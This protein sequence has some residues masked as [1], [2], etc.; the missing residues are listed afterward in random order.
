[1]NLDIFTL[2]NRCN[3]SIKTLRKLGDTVYTGGQAHTFIDRGSNV[4]AVAHI[5]TVQ[6]SRAF[7]VSTSLQVV[8]SP[9]LDD[10]LGVYTILDVLPSLGIVPD[11][12]LCEDEE[13]G[14][15][16]ATHFSTNKPYHWIVEFDRGGADVVNY[17]YSDRDWNNTLEAYFPDLGWGSYTDICDLEDL[18]VKAFNVGVGYHNPHSLNAFCFTQD[19][20]NNIE[21]F[22]AFW[23]DHKNTTFPHEPL[24]PSR[25]MNWDY[26]EGWRYRP[27]LTSKHYLDSSYTY[28]PLE[29]DGEFCPLCEH[30]FMDAQAL[31]WIRTLGL[32]PSCFRR[33][34]G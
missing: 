8:R 18:G 10:R 3:A 30:Y 24:P 4:L 27:V 26:T 12:L 17:D 28:T 14:R 9:R 21:R 6:S 34:G 13:R 31:E 11:V 23:N 1:M 2:H 33:Y 7:S 16:S 25:W 29:D 22:V 32:C 19:W 5:D 15:S 20:W